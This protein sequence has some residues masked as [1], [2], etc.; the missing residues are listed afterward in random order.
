MRSQP[1]LDSV[2]ARRNYVAAATAAGSMQPAGAGPLTIAFRPVASLGERVGLTALVALNAVT[3]VVFIAWL[4]RPQHIPGLDGHEPLLVA[5]PATLG[6]ALVLLV[7]VIRLL[8]NF[9]VW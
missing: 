7:E 3:A 9:A 8:Q 2:M 5:W 6:F 4:V 1:R